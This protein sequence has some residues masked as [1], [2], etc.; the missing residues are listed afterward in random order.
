MDRLKEAKQPIQWQIPAPDV[1]ELMR[2]DEMC[3]A[4][5]KFARKIRRKQKD[6]PKET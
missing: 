2:E 4:G 6:R 1:G 5:R 3:L